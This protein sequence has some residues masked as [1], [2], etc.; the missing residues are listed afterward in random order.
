ME[1]V[2]LPAFSTTE[3]STVS[4]SHSVNGSLPT[5]SERTVPRTMQHAQ[6]DDIT[7]LRA[8]DR[9]NGVDRDDALPRHASAGV[10]AWRAEVGNILET[11]ETSTNEHIPTIGE[12]SRPESLGDLSALLPTRR[13]RQPSPVDPPSPKALTASPTLTQ[14]PTSERPDMFHRRN[15]TKSFS[16]GERSPSGFTRPPMPQRGK[17]AVSGFS[18]VTPSRPTIGKS[19]SPLLPNMPP[20]RRPS[21]ASAYTSSPGPGRHRSKS[22]NYSTMYSSGSPHRSLASDASDSD[23]RSPVRRPSLQSMESAASTPTI[24]G[25]DESCF[26]L[27]RLVEEEKGAAESAAADQSTTDPAASGKDSVPEPESKPEEARKGWFSP[28]SYLQASFLAVKESMLGE[29]GKEATKEAGK[30]DAEA[31]T[32]WEFWGK[33]MNDYETTVRKHPRTFTRKVHQGIPSSLRGMVWQL[34]CKGKDP[35]L[36]RHYANLL[37]RTSLH[38]KVIQRDLART[39][40]KHERFQ[41]PAGPGQESLFNI[42][43]AYSLYDTEIGYCQGIAFVVGAL[44]LNMPDEEAFCVLVRLMKSYNLRDLYTPQMLGLQLRL[45]QFDQLLVEHFPLVARHLVAQEVQSNMYASQWFMTL[46]AYRFPLSAVFRIMDV[47]FA[48]GVDAMLRIALALIRANADAL[49]TMEFEPLLDFL[50]NGLFDVYA[51]NVNGLILDAAS[52]RVPA[53]RLAKL[54][55]DHEE[56]V[57]LAGPE[58][59]EREALRAETR[60]LGET[61]RRMDAEYEMLNREHVTL[62]NSF[63][64]QTVRGDNAAAT[65]AALTL[66]CADLE[67]REATFQREAEERCASDMARLAAKNL[68]LTSRVAA[69]A[70][71]NEQLRDRCDAS[72]ARAAKSDEDRMELERKWDGLKKVLG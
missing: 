43:K 46:F 69:L 47:I 41:D 10:E 2:S 62:A 1:A 56:A 63:L 30:E 6:S 40:P 49:V 65:A 27:D 39:F 11:P 3:Y 48:E 38:E 70:E 42:I 29:G 18:T 68:E 4:A 7:A 16:G 33:V 60:R 23:G 72:D 31:E 26:I 9:Q 15:T 24:L 53:T 14:E 19:S 61:I 50:K 21:T 67:Q 25:E 5:S 55:T 32:D 58:Y 71:D 8:A 20:P 45:F 37:T 44:L 66:R 51:E 54:A 17:S 13:N 36:E 22:E 35:A 57:K 34:I 64:E 59:M 12:M 28:A 52:I